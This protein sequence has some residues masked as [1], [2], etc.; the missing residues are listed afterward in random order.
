MIKSSQMSSV[1]A[2]VANYGFNDNA[3]R[4]RDFISQGIDTHLVDAS[5]PIPLRDADAII[6]NSYYPGLWN[7]AVSKALEGGYEWLFFIASD[8]QLTQYSM[9]FSCID[10]VKDIPDIF[11]WS[12]SIQPGSRFSSKE[13]AHN[14]IGILR[15]CRFVE[16]FCFLARM[17]LL[18]K[19]YP[20]PHDF[21]YGWN[22]DVIT[23]CLAQSHGTIVVDDRVQIF[24]PPSLSNH[25]I[26]EEY[27]AREGLAYRRL[28]A[29]IV[30]KEFFDAIDQS[31]NQ[32][33]A[34]V[35]MYGTLRSLDLGCGEQPRNIFGI[36]DAWGLDI[37]NPHNHTNIKT[38]DLA[39]EQIP[40]SDGYFSHITAFDFIEHIPRVLYLP[41]RRFP[42]VELMNEIY[43]V[44]M[45]GGVFL[46]LTP[47]FPHQ[48]AF[49]DPTHVNYI[50]DR[51]IKCYFCEPD[52]WGS[53]YGFKG[54]FILEHQELKDQG[55][56]LNIVRAVK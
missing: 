38:A 53:M 51:T 43:R 41:K 22:I 17:S 11:L 30:N 42:F 10:E 32:D 19:Q 26:D 2:V 28:F 21:K 50:T 44:L 46:S 1:L 20:L 12:P 3:L 4:L 55:K 56:L 13:C 9:F 49:Q 36:S 5:S 18:Q 24:H 7:Y 16:G 31:F 25:K 14:P 52:L 39:V 29:N 34:E 48:E 33:R 35:S 27:A 54:R 23:S 37:R 47:S 8:V 15:K 6:A 40:F 45:P